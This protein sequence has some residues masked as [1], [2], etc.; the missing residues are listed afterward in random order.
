VPSGFAAAFGKV[1]SVSGSTITIEGTVVSFQS[2][3]TSRPGTRTTAVLKP[4]RVSVAV[5]SKTRYLRTGPAT[6]ASLKVGQCATAFGPTNDIGA[7]TATRLSVSPASGSGCSAGGFGGFG[8]F[9][10]GGA[11]A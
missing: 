10:G 8:G 7:V 4:K 3:P 2:A 9:G 5:S 1:T 11:G 6:V